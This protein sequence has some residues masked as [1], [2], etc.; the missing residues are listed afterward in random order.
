MFGLA[1]V[2]VRGSNPLSSTHYFFC[3]IYL[4]MPAYFRAFNR[5]TRL[6]DLPGFGGGLERNWRIGFGGSKWGHSVL[7]SIGVKRVGR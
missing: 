6:V 3:G 5:F 7:H 2:G 1:T 4:Y